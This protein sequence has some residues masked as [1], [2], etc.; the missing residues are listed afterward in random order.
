MIFTDEW[1]S[2]TI[3][4]MVDKTID[5]FTKINYIKSTKFMKYYKSYKIHINET[6]CPCGIDVKRSLL[7]ALVVYIRANSSV[8]KRRHYDL[9]TLVL[10]YAY[11]LHFNVSL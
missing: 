6:K 2:N 5:A 3:K 11:T 7:R 9:Q 1:C 8:E 4:K 10:T